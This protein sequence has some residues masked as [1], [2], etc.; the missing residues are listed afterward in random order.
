MIMTKAVIHTIMRLI[1]VKTIM[2]A[3]A[4]PKMHVS[5]V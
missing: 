5:A 1:L 4:V 3:Q 2:H